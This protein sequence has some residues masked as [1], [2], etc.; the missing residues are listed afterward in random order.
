MWLCRGVGFRGIG[1]PRLQSHIQ[2]LKSST[3]PHPLTENVIDPRKDRATRPE[4]GGQTSF[5]D[6]GRFAKLL[7]HLNVGTSKRVY[8]L[9]GV[10]HHK[11]GARGELACRVP[12]CEQLHDFDLQRVGVL[13]L[14]HEQT[15][16][17]ALEMQTG[18]GV[19]PQHVAG[20]NEQVV[21]TRLPR[22]TPH[23]DL[24][25]HHAR[26]WRSQLP[27]HSRANLA[28]PPFDQVVK[29]REFF[30]KGQEGVPSLVV[31]PVGSVAQPARGDGYRFFAGE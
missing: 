18:F 11:E 30:P 6:L 9:L 27:N 24:F 4:I 5:V 25:Q 29:V 12:P 23:L 19:I 20:P 7:G 3:V 14:I 2:C 15:A 21:E 1:K 22:S 26:D 10:A 13:E 8:R 16:K 17:A 31:R 28:K